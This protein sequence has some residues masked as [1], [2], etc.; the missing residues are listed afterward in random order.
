MNPNL[1]LELGPCFGL[2]GLIFGHKFE[3][4]YDESEVG[5][6]N[7]ATE[8]GKILPY[9][10]KEVLLDNDVA[11]INRITQALTTLSEESI[12]VQDVCVRCGAII[13]RQDGAE[14]EVDEQ[15]SGLDSDKIGQ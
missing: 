13:E 5:D 15:R 11:V 12:Y 9:Y 6:P 3:P 10:R 2:M 8:L 1:G 4:R 14:E 7:A